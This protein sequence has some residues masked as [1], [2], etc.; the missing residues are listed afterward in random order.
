[1]NNYDAIIQGLTREVMA[2]REEVE[3]ISKLTPLYDMKN[4]DGYA[5]LTA[6]QNNYALGTFDFI[7]LNPTANR[8]INGMT[9][10]YKGR[11]LYLKNVSNSFTISFTN[12]NAS[13]ILE[14]R[15]TTPTVATVVLA[16]RQ[17]AVFVYDSD[18]YYI[19]TNLWVMIFPTA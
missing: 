8:T 2:L 14:N 5:N 3:R 19:G 15:I 10:G 4:V 9:N 16:V 6:D 13:A 7:K 18:P 12:Q 11:T 1:M 17:T